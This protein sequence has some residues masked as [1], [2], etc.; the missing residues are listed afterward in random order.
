MNFEFNEKTGQFEYKDPEL[1]KKAEERR[2]NKQIN[3]E[4]QQRL[5]G[6]KKT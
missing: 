1:R 3:D 6:L 5:S 4:L 2:E